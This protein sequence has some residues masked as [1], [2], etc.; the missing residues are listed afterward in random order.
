MEASDGVVG[1]VVD[2]MIDG[3]TWMI[4]EI[5]VECGHWYDGKKMMIPTGKVS[6]ISYKEEAISVDSTKSVLTDAA[7]SAAS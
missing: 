1:E 4:G 2:F 3:R 5:V 6:R 7:L